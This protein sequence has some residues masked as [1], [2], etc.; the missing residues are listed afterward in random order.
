MPSYLGVSA[1]SH[2]LLFQGTGLWKGSGRDAGVWGTRVA[3]LPGLILVGDDLAGWPWTMG[4]RDGEYHY[5][6]GA[7]RMHSTA[8]G[9]CIELGS[10]PSVC[11]GS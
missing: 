1:C 2:I 11:L 4:R 8:K 3:L 5:R 9:L 7:W 10:Q 6:A